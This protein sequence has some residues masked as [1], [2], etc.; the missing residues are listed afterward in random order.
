MISKTGLTQHATN[1]A[2]EQHNKKLCY[3]KEDSA[4]VVIALSYG[5]KGVLI[6][7]IVWAWIIGVADGRT[8]GLTTDSR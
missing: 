5:A 6:C 1:L 2:V 3:R 7:W 8:D 4:S